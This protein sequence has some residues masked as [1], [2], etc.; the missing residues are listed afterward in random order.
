MEN[1]GLPKR[2]YYRYL[3]LM[4]WIIHWTDNQRVIGLRVSSLIRLF[5][6]VVPLWIW[7]QRWHQTWLILAILIFLWIQFSYWRGRRSGYYRFVVENVDLL[8]SSETKPLPAN[9]H[10]PVY[11]TGIF[12]LKSWESNV[13]FRPAEYW[14]VPLGDHAVMVLYEPGRFLYQFISAKSM[15][16]LQKGWLLFGSR[17][18]PALSIS[19]LSTWGP[20]FDDLNISMLG[21]NRKKPEEKVRTIYLSFETEDYEEAVWQ[22]LLFDA[23]RVRSNGEN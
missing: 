21:I 11:A 5:S 7:I 13:V 8:S 19:F 6:L 20:E 16:E 10:I 4:Y 15:L 14:Q 9:H 22:N 1:I 18:S 12:S 2:V 17:P 3:G 23:R